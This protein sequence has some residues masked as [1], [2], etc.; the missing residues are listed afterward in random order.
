MNYVEPEPYPLQYS[1]LFSRPGAKIGD[2]YRIRPV[3]GGYTMD[4]E[5]PDVPDLSMVRA[6]AHT[7]TSGLSEAGVV[8]ANA[9]QIHWL[10]TEIASLQSKY[11]L[12]AS[13]LEIVQQ[14]N[15]ELRYALDGGRELL[16][17]CPPLFAGF[18]PLAEKVISPV[19]AAL[20]RALRLDA[21]LNAYG[22][23]D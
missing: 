7:L 19:S 18:E 23:K 3:P 14:E 4:K 10:E 16:E 6:R 2:T 12:A 11:D 8:A 15:R 1:E 17:L 13:A 20:S 9:L 5:P 22:R 21:P